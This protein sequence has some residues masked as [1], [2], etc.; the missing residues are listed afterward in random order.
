MYS[1]SYLYQ[2]MG[3]RIFA[4]RCERAAFNALP[5]MFTSDLWAHQYLVVPNQPV[6]QALDGPNPF[7]NTGDQSILYGIGTFLHPS[8]LDSHYR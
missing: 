2:A 6:A 8:L 1:L 7:F 3:D 4:D 5:V